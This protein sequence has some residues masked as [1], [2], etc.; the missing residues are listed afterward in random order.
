MSAKQHK[1]PIVLN[2]VPIKYFSWKW[3]LLLLISLYLTKVFAA[4]IKPMVEIESKIHNKK[5]IILSK[6]PIYVPIF[7]SWLLFSSLKITLKANEIN[8]PVGFTNIN[9]AKIDIKAIL[10]NMIVKFIYDEHK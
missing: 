2:N 4:I 5:I 3:F 10:D 9:I 7:N 6:Y 8:T 1:A